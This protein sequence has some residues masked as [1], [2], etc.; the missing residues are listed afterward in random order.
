MNRGCSIFGRFQIVAER[1]TE[2]RFIAGIDLERID[3]ARPLVGH[4]VAQQLGQ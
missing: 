2:S 3:D 1:R 4:A